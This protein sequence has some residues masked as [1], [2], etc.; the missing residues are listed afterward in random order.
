ME[1]LKGYYAKVRGQQKWQNATLQDELI[2]LFNFAWLENARLL[3]RREG[4]TYNFM[5][6]FLSELQD[7]LP[8]I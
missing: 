5:A 7:R 4:K 3:A 2:A 1:I 6:S 8:D